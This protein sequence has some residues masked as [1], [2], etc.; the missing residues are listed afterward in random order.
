MNERV[1]RDQRMEG[2]ES[3]FSHYPGLAAL[4]KAAI[5]LTGEAG[6]NLIPSQHYIVGLAGI[7]GGLVEVA[8]AI[9]RVANI[10]ERKLP[11]QPQIRR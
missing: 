5:Q 11:E 1:P 4:R 7:I 2:G 8:V 10:L 9:H 3:M 6:R